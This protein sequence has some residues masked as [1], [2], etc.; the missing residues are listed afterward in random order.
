MLQESKNL[1][2]YW[3]TYYFEKL[4]AVFYNPSGGIAATSPLPGEAQNNKGSLVGGSKGT[5]RVLSATAVWGSVSSMLLTTPPLRL[6][7][8]TTPGS[9]AQPPH[10]GGLNGREA[11]L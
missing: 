8:A 11:P 6:R 9:A 7:R 2:N 10:R 4:G 5:A 1:V 3:E